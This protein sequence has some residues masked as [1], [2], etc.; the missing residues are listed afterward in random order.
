MSSGFEDALDRI[1]RLRKDK[2]DIYFELND[3]T[4]S[5]DNK[6]SID[7]YRSEEKI[8]MNGLYYYP[9]SI[10]KYYPEHTTVPATVQEAS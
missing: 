4:E 5:I 9:S 6:L 8:Y 10:S 7:Y 1:S 2:K 3:E